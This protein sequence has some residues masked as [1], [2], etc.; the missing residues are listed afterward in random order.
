MGGRH[1]G[2]L[3]VLEEVRCSLEPA[4]S[5]LKLVHRFL[6]LIRRSLEL[7]RRFLELVR[8]R[9]LA[10]TR[11]RDD[12]ILCVRSHACLTQAVSRYR[13]MVEDVDHPYHYPG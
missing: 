3:A 7:I 13:D 9:P 5:S 1:S 10:I 4:C 12:Y 2:N 6:E 11:V 8:R